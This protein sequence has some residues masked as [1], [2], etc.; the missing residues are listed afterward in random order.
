M[1]PFLAVVLF[2]EGG[3]AVAVQSLLIIINPFSVLVISLRLP[4]SSSKT[5][6]VPPCALGTF[7]CPWV[8]HPGLN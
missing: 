3:F 7:S 2:G 4:P 1:E 5:P 6:L 8:L